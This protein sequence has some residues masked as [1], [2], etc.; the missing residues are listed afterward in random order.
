VKTPDKTIGYLHDLHRG[1]LTINGLWCVTRNDPKYVRAAQAL[2]E[3]VKSI[4]RA[5][6]ALKCAD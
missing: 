6:Y 1:L 5:Q 2:Q 4:E 3:A